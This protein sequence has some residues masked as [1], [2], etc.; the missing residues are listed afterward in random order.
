MLACYCSAESKS[1]SSGSKSTRTAKVPLRTSAN[2]SC[3]RPSV[4]ATGASLHESAP[5]HHLATCRLT[6][7]MAAVRAH[8]LRRQ[9][10]R[11]CISSWR[12]LQMVRYRLQVH[13]VAQLVP[14]GIF[15]IE[16]CAKHEWRLHGLAS[17]QHILHMPF[18]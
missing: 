14:P 18:D 4:R 3:S 6:G 8:R 13:G 17:R 12:S 11:I 10:L 15:A 1:P 2:S 9:L 5:E 7:C 16:R